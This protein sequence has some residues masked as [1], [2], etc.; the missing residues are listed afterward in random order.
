[1]NLRTSIQY[2]TGQIQDLADT[3]LVKEHY[4]PKRVHYLD[5]NS[6]DIIVF[7]VKV[8]R[9]RKSPSEQLKIHE[10]DTQ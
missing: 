4:C 8:Y 3:L 10:D 7:L 2:I 5:V 9:K 1:M 6:N